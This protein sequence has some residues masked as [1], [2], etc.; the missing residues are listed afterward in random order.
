MNAE[1][2]V[3]YRFIWAWNDQKEEKWLEEMAAQGWHLV[4]GGIRFVF[5]RGEPRRMRYRLDYRASYPRGKDEYFSLYRDAGWEYVGNYFGWHYFRSPAESAAPEIFTDVESRAAK[6]T[7]VLMLLGGAL[8]AN[9]CF[10]PNAIAL[11]SRPD[12]ATPLKSLFVFQLVLIAVL[13]LI[14]I[15]L[16]VH[17]RR[18]RQQ[19]AIR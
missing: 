4:S 9:L 10:V 16:L 1:R 11:A 3:K 18:I 14:A 13:V 15:R 6:Y 7:A 12:V 19:S 5:E 8:A 2:L 17:I